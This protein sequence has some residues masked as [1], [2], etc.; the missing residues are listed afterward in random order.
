MK[1]KNA[2]NREQHEALGAE[3]Q[4][5]RD[6]LLILSFAIGRRYGRTTLAAR[7]AEGARRAV[8]R[9]RSAMER[10]AA[11]DLGDKFNVHLYFPGA[12]PAES[13]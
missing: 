3:F 12:T 4:V 9:L 1:P 2:F 5:V 8:D 11:V 7:Q 10:T 13:T 6:R